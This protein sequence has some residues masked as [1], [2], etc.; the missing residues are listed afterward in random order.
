MKTSSSRGDTNPGRRFGRRSLIAG[1]GGLAALAAVSCGD[2]D[3][4]GTGQSTGSPAAQATKEPKKG[5]TLTA[6]IAATGLHYDQH[7]L[8]GIAGDG[9]VYNQLFKLGQGQKVMNDLVEKHETPEPNV[10]IF[11]VRQGVK[12][13]NVAPVNGRAMTAKDVVYTIERSRTDNAAFSNR[14]MW[15]SLASLQAIDDNTV[16][17]TFAQ[18]FAPALYHF[19]APSM[20]VI[21]KEVVDQFGDLKDWKSRIGT[22]PYLLK[23]VKKDELVAYKRNPG[24]FD[25]RLPYIDEFQYPVIPDRLGRIVALRTGQVD[26]IGWQSGVADIE[27]AKRGMSDVS[28][29][30]RPSDA[31]TALAPN[32]AMGVLGDERIRQAIA[33]AIDHQELIRAAGGE[34]AGVVKGFTHPNGAPFALPDAEIA[35]FTRP[36]PAKARQ[37]LSAAGQTNLQLSVTVSS[38]DTTAMDLAAVMQQQMQK[39]GIKLTIDPQES[40]TYVRKLS[41]KAFELIWIGSWTPALD[42]SQQFHG[43]LR[44]DAAQ[45]W[46]NAKV[47]EMNALDDKQVV[48]LDTNKRALIVQEME[49]L[50]F[51]KVIALPLYV[52]NGW[53]AMKNY[54]KDYDHLRAFNSLGWQDGVTWL[55]K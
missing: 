15:T 28:V 31:V 39:V 24:Y 4:G 12:F 44:S 46:W 2:D 8:P 54:I 38:T 14:W 13:Q 53:S 37:L 52:V 29:L 30:T 51:K 34:N 35:E 43:S 22:G 41:T 36:D 21:A 40:A 17:A 11:T 23:E 7:Q 55:D 3:S 16:K 48:E 50:N 20:G 49:R 6:A 5:G 18:P 33:A 1:A 25:P 47:T 10:F 45:N 9:K 42:P 32:H 19:A 26:M 27:E